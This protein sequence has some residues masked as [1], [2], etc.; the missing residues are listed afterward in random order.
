[1]ANSDAVSGVLMDD[2]MEGMIT[3]GAADTKNHG[4]TFQRDISISVHQTIV[5]LF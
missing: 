5:F 2:I 3:E 1:M 4:A